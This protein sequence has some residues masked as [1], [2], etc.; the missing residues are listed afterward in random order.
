MNEKPHQL[1]GW[2]V[3]PYT[4]KTRAHLMA[5]RIA[6]EE[7]TPSVFTLA[8]KI[9]KKVGRAI[10]P[11][12]QT[13]EGQWLQDS[14]ELFDY[15]ESIHQGPAFVPTTPK[16]R[17]LCY[18]LECFA[19]EWLPM[20]ALHY[21]WNTPENRTFALSEFSKN[22]MPYWPSFIRNRVAYSLSSRLTGYL[23]PLG[24]T[25]DT[26]PALE[27]TTKIVIAAVENTLAHHPYLLGTRP[28]LA[29]FALYGPLWAH[30][31]R[32]PGSRYL[33][34]DAPHTVAWFSRLGTSSSSEQTGYLDED[35]I[36]SS[37]T[38]LLKILFDDQWTWIQTLVQAIDTYCAEHPDTHRV[39]RALGWAPFTTRGYTGRRKLITFVQWKAQRARS[40]Y[41]T[42]PEKEHAAM[43]DWLHGI[44]GDPFIQCVIRHPF[45]RHR[46]KC[47]LRDTA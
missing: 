30:L 43:T 39:P 6:Y 19:D 28:S 20:V 27:E 34:A 40:I 17:L 15:F 18:L 24:V 45:K 35:A 38:P 36:P 22:G 32:D 2:L 13:P 21:R 42:L 46:F 23:E 29:D 3:S 7:C 26:L 33:F 47:V 16:Q 14:S 9:R 1:Y 41:D 37:L 4:A 8:G 25:K 31:Y 10:M 11:T 5:S 12:V 44:G